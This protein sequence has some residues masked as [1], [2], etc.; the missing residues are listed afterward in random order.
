MKRLVVSL[1]GSF[2]DSD[3]RGPMASN[4]SSQRCKNFE[5]VALLLKEWR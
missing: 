1:W 5:A 2:P 4:D 3:S